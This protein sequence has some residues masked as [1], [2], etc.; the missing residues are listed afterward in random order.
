MSTQITIPARHR[1][2][3]GR[4]WL[5]GAILVVSLVVAGASYVALRDGGAPSKRAPASVVAQVPQNT[6]AFTGSDGLAT[7]GTDA[8]SL[9]SVAQ[10]AALTR[11]AAQRPG[12]I[13]TEV[14][15]GSG[16]GGGCMA[17]GRQPC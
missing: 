16:S 3:F 13:G 6:G 2:D 15:G 8:V 9:P 11:H 4:G 14:R 5:V 10:H 7:R 1:T 17:V 12:L